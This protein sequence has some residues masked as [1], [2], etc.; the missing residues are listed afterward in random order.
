ME[1]DERKK[2]INIAG[3]PPDAFSETGQRWGNPL[4]NWD[5]ME[6]D[7]FAWWYKRMESSAKLYDVTRIDHFIGIVRYFSIP[8]ECETAEN[9]VYKKGPGKK[10]TDV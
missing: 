6:Q 5:R 1:L 4:Y 8:V 7:D 2:P 3:V 10:L 9:G